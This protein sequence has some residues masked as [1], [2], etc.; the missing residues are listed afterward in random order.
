MNNNNKELHVKNVTIDFIE[1][2]LKLINLFLN[3]L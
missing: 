1:Y 3:V 2:N